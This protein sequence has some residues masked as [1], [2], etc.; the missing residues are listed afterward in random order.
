MAPDGGPGPLINR[1][2]PDA[3]NAQTPRL[4]FGI[5]SRRVEEYETFELS[6]TARPSG[7]CQ[8]GRQSVPEG[9]PPWPA[10]AT[11]SKHLQ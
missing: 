5:A 6:H 10:T 3:A 2:Q 4:R 11:A 7:G 8:A 1:Q 9:V